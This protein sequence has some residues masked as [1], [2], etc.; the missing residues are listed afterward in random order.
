[1]T[2]LL[3]ASRHG[4]RSCIGQ[5]FAQAEF[6]CLLAAWVGRFETKFEEGSALA[7]GEL[8]IKGNITAKPK[9]GLWVELK[10]LD[11]W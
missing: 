1:M 7:R 2:P 4:P 9:D 5:K 8:D 10:E 11:G 3:I 6:E